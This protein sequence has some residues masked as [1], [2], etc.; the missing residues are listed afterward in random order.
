VIS[1]DKA[2]LIKIDPAT[3]KVVSRTRFATLIDE[4]K[5]H[6]KAAAGKGTDSIWLDVL[7]DEGG[8]GIPAGLLR[9]D[10]STGTGQS[11]LSL[12]PAQAGD[13]SLAVT[14]T[15]VWLAGSE[16]YSR[17]DVATNKISATYPTG[18]GRLKI[19]VAFGSVWL[20][21]Y[22]QDLIQRL[23]FKP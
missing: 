11:F 5:A 20:R 18:S 15:S 21:N 10:P 14:D 13:G 16:G 7:G 8:G 4:A 6:T 1:C 2:E 12:S 3:D 17:V 23:D 9:V 22:E 19:G